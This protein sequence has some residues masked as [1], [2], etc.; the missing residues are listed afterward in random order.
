MEFALHSSA[1]AKAS[2][3]D[4][5]LILTLVQNLEYLYRTA[6]AL[7]LSTDDVESALAQVKNQTLSVVVVGEFKRGK[8]T[9]I[10]A[11]LGQDI[12]PSDILPTTSTINRVV[13]G[14]TPS[15]T[16]RFKDGQEQSIAIEQLEN[17]VTK[18]TSDAEAIS[19]R[20]QEALIH[21][22]LHYCRNGVEII[23]TPGL[24]DDGIMTEVTL[25]VLRRTEVVIMVTSAISPFAESEGAFLTHTLLEQGIDHILFVVNG[26]DHFKN[27]EDVD[28]VLQS[29]KQRI[30]KHIHDWANDQFGEESEEYEDYMKRTGSPRIYGLSSKQALQG[31]CTG[32]ALLLERSRFQEFETSLNHLLTEERQRISLQMSVEG[33]IAA[34]NQILNSIKTQY[35]ALQSQQQSFVRQSLSIVES[36]SSL[37]K[38]SR[39]EWKHLDRGIVN[40]ES[41]VTAILRSFNYRL[42]QAVEQTID[43]TSVD[44]SSHLNGITNHFADQVVNILKEVT[45]IIESNITRIANQETE[46]QS[47]RLKTIVNSIDQQIRQIQDQCL[48]IG[49]DLIIK[50]SVYCNTDNQ[51][52]LHHL[53]NLFSVDSDLFFIQEQAKGGYTVTGAAI[54]A[55]FGGFGAPV[56]AAIGAS[57]GEQRRKQTFKQFYKPEALSV[58]KAKLSSQNVDQK[59]N[60]YIVLATSNLK[61]S[62]RRAR[63]QTEMIIDG[64][65]QNVSNFQGKRDAATSSEQN[66]LDQLMSEIQTILNDS[67]HFLSRLN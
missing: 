33:A 45:L 56:G 15:V 1:P 64:I 19:G 62:T 58:L 9:F 57:L 42:E 34:A 46:K 31:K 50:D 52:T 53:S 18:L 13:F 47:A 40:I 39:E 59:V 55:L 66:R 38:Q 23:D 27:S 32:D 36:I 21:Y 25:S 10:N 20:V 17:Y 60:Q 4:R 41:E 12:L 54:G 5:Q 51:I 8:S 7:D 6:K 43:N 26:I 49:I 67:H 28:R 16:V 3:E 37:R 35:N 24:N 2:G 61:T 44:M 29:I 48:K 30:Q 65:E 11:L 63:Q 14:L 22:P